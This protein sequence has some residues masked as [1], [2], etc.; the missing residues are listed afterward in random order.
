MVQNSKPAQDAGIPLFYAA[1]FT[2]RP[3]TLSL[4]G[5]MAEQTMVSHSASRRPSRSR[6]CLGD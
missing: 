6:K 5:V 1:S 3:E 2:A 4:E